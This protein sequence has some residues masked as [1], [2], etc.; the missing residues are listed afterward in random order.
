MKRLQ[1]GILVLCLLAACRSE[2][3]QRVEAELA[4]GVR[5][6]SLFLG[7]TFGMS[8]KEFYAHC[9]QLNKQGLIQ[10]GTQNTTVMQE[11]STLKYPATMNFYPN[12]HE[13]KIYEMPVTYAYKAWAPWNRHLFAD[14]LQ[15]HVLATY[16]QHYGEDFM[17]IEHPQKGIAYVRVDGNR[18]ISIFQENDTEVK[19]LFTDL[20][21]DKTFKGKENTDLRSQR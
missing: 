9:W 6:D 13:D 4:K 17:R 21:V 7:I 11:V 2:Y 20:L 3:H 10:Q 5:Q 14:S 8:S 18:R 15:Q 16:Q 12:F 19:V 1:F